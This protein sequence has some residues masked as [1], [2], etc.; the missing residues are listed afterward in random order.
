[1]SWAI[2]ENIPGLVF[3]SIHSHHQEEPGGGPTHYPQWA[4]LGTP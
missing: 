4:N 1:V 2:V 3:I